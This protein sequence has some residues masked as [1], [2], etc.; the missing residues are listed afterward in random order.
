M[1]LSELITL[2]RKYIEQEHPHLTPTAP[3]AV[4]QEAIPILIVHGEEAAEE[5]ALLERM[6]Q[7]LCE[8]VAFTKLIKKEES[9]SPSKLLVMTQRAKGRAPP[10]EAFI[11]PPLHHFVEKPQTRKLLWQQLLERFEAATS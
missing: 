10:P 11:L 5:L 1:D 8:K 7:A 4:Q 3:P 6:V 2:T 9:F